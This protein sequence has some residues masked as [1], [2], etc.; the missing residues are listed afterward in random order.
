MHSTHIYVHCALSSTS[1]TQVFS[2]LLRSFILSFLGRTDAL[3][4]RFSTV[5]SPKKDDTPWYHQIQAVRAFH[6]SNPCV[7]IPSLANLLLRC[8]QLSLPTLPRTLAVFPSTLPAPPRAWNGFVK[9]FITRSGS[10][11]FTEI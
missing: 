8:H 7:A 5:S 10:R 6:F 11:C 1:V 4:F 2:N 9:A 3:S